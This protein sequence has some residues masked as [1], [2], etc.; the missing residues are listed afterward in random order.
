MRSASARIVPAGPAPR[1]PTGFPSARSLLQW[2][3]VGRVALSI[4]VFVAAAFSFRAIDPGDLVILAIA[5]IASVIVTALSV[6][7]THLRR[8]EPGL[9]FLYVQAV[10]DLALVTTVVH[11]TEGPASQFPALYIPVIAVASVLMPFRA[12]FLVTVLA[13]LLYLADITWWQP[14]ELSV[15]VW[16]QVAVFVAV[17]MATGFLA[18]RI[19]VVREEHQVLQREVRRLR[20]EAS[21]ILRNIRSAVVTVDGSGVLVFA[22]PA[23]LGLLG[24][25]EDGIGDT[26]AD[27][28]GD[29]APSLLE[30]IART[31][32]SGLRGIRSDGEVHVD[33]RS[34]P[35]GV[36][37]T[38]I[39][40]GEG[41]PP[42][43]TAIFTDISE[44]KRN[45]RRRSHMRSATR[46][47][48][49]GPPS[50]RSSIRWA[51]T[52]TSASWRS[53]C[54]GR[55]IGSPGC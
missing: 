39:E 21:D 14:V 46:S 16:L 25:G 27:L 13:S 40:A 28:V 42:S 8:A 52:P 43:V 24:I 36:T 44:Q 41:V 7:H 23:A 12:S 18:S 54:C 29:R 50:S 38:S 17:F 9:T 26:L 11:V 51:R 35:I 5:A 20:L 49:S 2:L 34:F 10:F 48:R 4:V 45:S 32:S 47:P 22:N 31:Q 6:W 1:S 37:T 33:G 3:Y 55:A 19:R 30:A 53:W 15:A